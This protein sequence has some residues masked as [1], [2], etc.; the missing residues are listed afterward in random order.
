MLQIYPMTRTGSWARG[1]EGLGAAG[2]TVEGQDTLLIK[3]E[4][5]WVIPSH[6]WLARRPTI[7]LAAQRRAVAPTPPSRSEV[8]L[9]ASVISL[10]CE[11]HG[12]REPVKTADSRHCRSTLR[13]FLFSIIIFLSVRWNVMP[14]NAE[15]FSRKVLKLLLGCA[16]V[17]P[18]SGKHL[19]KIY[20]NRSI[21]CAHDKCYAGRYKL[22]VICIDKSYVLPLVY[23][24]RLAGIRLFD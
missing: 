5:A 9:K 23:W 2:L 17:G 22:A 19:Q 6:P 3:P 15:T 11:E 21:I 1:L 24:R 13:P 7:P 18:I 8:W 16:R 20:E 14:L 12:G 10:T 4:P